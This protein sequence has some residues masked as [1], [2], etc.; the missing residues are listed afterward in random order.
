MGYSNDDDKVEVLNPRDGDLTKLEGQTDYA[1]GHC[2]NILNDI[3]RSYR[4]YELRPE[5]LVEIATTCW[6]LIKDNKIQIKRSPSS[7]SHARPSP[8]VVDKKEEKFMSR[9]KMMNP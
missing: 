8:H 2:S 1:K 4:N 3:E 6:D 9:N 7:H 5:H